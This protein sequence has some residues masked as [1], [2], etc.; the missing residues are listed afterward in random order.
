[1]TWFYKGTPISSITDIPVNKAVGFIYIIT[2]ISTGKRYIGKKLLSKST[3]KTKAGK[4]RKIRVESDWLNYWSSS[5]KILHLITENGTHD[6]TREILVFV[7]SRGMM[8]YAEEAALYM[9]GA[10][11]SENWFNDNIRS[12]VYRSWCKPTEAVELRKSLRHHI[13]F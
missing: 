3:T 12:K 13:N 11:E 9:A 10:L 7:T 6:F 1:M 8:V 5:P 4:K 2:Q